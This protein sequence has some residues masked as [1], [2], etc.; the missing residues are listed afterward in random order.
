MVLIEVLC[1]FVSKLM[2][3]DQTPD[4]KI[5]KQGQLIIRARN[6][7]AAVNFISAKSFR[8]RKNYY[9]NEGE[10]FITRA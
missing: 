5:V 10:R 2:R 9:S 1:Y 7:R 8:A 3:S 6:L 4:V